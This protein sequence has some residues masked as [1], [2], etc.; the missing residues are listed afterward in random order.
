LEVYRITK[1]FPKE[2]MFG[3]TSQFRRAAASIPANLAEGS[4]RTSQKEFHQFIN[5][6][7]GSTAEV[8]VWLQLGFDLEYMT[9]QAYNSLSEKCSEIGRLL[10]G[11][12]SSVR[13]SD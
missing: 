6:A 7:R 13:K 8:E 2:E 10:F 4:T 9:Q 1:G 3:L 5:I 11:L 12:I